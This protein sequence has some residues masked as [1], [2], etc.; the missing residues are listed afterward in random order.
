MKNKLTIVLVVIL[1][2]S[3][4]IFSQEKVNFFDSSEIYTHL[5]SEVK[6]NLKG[7]LCLKMK[8]KGI[9]FLIY[10]DSNSTPIVSVYNKTYIVKDSIKIVSKGGLNIKII[11]NNSD[12]NYWKIEKRERTPIRREMKKYKGG[13]KFEKGKTVKS[14]KKEEYEIIFNKKNR[15]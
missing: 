13:L 14:L 10:I 4:T 3:I 8:N 11:K 5:M 2:K 12:T 7:E 15:D 9:R 1:L 6:T